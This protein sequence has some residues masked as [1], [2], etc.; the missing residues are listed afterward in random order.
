[1]VFL[2]IY[3]RMENQNTPK[4]KPH[5]KSKNLKKL[6]E[7][8]RIGRRLGV[9]GIRSEDS[10]FE[11]LKR[12]MTK[13]DLMIYTNEKLEDQ[14]RELIASR[15]TSNLQD[16]SKQVLI[17][18][19]PPHIREELISKL[20]LEILALKRDNDVLKSVLRETKA[21]IWPEGFLERN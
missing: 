10:L 7:Y 2:S 12:A 18:D 13:L 3:F 8:K 19:T 11:L 14:I 16:Q 4:R 21:Q 9:Q 15:S 17:R 5:R 6:E 1:M 20:R